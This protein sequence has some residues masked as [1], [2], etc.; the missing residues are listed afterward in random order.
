M[1]FLEFGFHDRAWRFFRGGLNGLIYEQPTPPSYGS[2]TSYEVHSG[3]LVAVGVIQIAL[4]LAS[5]LRE[6]VWHRRND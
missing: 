4:L 2:V 6:W 5:G 1:L 3:I